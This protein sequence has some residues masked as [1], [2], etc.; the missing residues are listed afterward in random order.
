MTS[1]MNDQSC[2]FTIRL[3]VVCCSM[4]LLLSLSSCSLDRF[5]IRQTQVFEA[6]VNKTAIVEHLNRNI[7]GTESSPGV[8]AWRTSDAKVQVT[9]IPFPLPASMAVEAPNNLRIIVTHPISGGQEVDLGSN[10]D[11]FWL[12]TKEQTEMITCSHED[13]SLAL[14]QFEMPIQIQP[15]WLMEV[16]GVVPIN[17]ADYSLERPSTDEPIVDLVAHKTN[18]TGQRVERVIRVNTYSGTVDQH[19]LRN[20]DG[21]VIATAKLDKYT[22]MPNGTVLPTYVKISWPAAKTEMKISLGHPEV[23][24]PGFAGAHTMWDRP[25]I[26][27]SKVVDI[28]MLSRRAA[29]M[30]QQ[31]RRVAQEDSPANNIRQLRHTDA[32]P[33]PESEV[34]ELPGQV[35]LNPT[36]RLQAPQPKSASGPAETANATDWSTPPS[37]PLD[38]GLPAWAQEHSTQKPPAAPDL[39]VQPASQRATSVPVTWQPST[40][41]PTTWRSS[42]V[43]RHPAQE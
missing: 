19:L 35:A 20:S 27:G 5:R 34:E 15:E 39:Q 24:P 16:F 41:S 23:N 31:P 13:T 11:G 1:K 7:L 38:D 10:P 17:E 37:Q 26:P 30:Q 32:A 29:G 12:W 18:P 2:G 22:K 40:Y 25:N 43:P 8:S 6:D 9:G 14:Q 21:E 28:G 42:S 36:Q 4:V 3:S 33:F